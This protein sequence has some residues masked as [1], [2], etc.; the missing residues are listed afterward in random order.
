M[1][2]DTSAIIAILFGEAEADRLID[3]LSDA[4]SL[5]ISAATLV[6]IG[7]VQYAANGEPGIRELTALMSELVPVVVPV[8]SDQAHIAF[9][10][11]QRYG[12]GQHRARLN[13]GDC[14]SYALAK[15]TGQPLLFKGND[16]S[17]TDLETVA[18]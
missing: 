5:F 9:Q 17:L 16:F 10:A 18:F 3:V 15:E 6:E 14:F 13:F 7:I 11:F 2:V 1:V 8:T 4:D 12:R